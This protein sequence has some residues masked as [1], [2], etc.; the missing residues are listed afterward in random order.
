MFFKGGPQG[1]RN[2]RRFGRPDRGGPLLYPISKKS[3]SKSRKAELA[4]P[5][6]PN[7][8]SAVADMYIAYTHIY[9]YGSV[10]LI[11]DRGK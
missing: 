8:Q 3:K 11:H 6:T 5:V 7:A 9:T 2:P 4:S 10:S 1:R